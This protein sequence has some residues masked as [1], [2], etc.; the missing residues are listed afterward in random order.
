MTAKVLRL[1]GSC[2]PHAPGGSRAFSP[3][4]LVL[5]RPVGRGGVQSG[6]DVST[7]QRALN[8]VPPELGGPVEKLNPDGLVGHFTLGAIEKFQLHHF[9]F[10][11]GRVDVFGKTHAKLSSMRPAK[12]AFVS[13]A[14]ANLNEA[15]R[16]IRAAGAKL[17]QAQTELLTGGGLLGRRNLDLVDLH[18]GVLKSPN[19]REAIDRLKGVYDRMLAVFARPGGLWGVNA[20]DADPFTEPDAGAFT[21]WGGFDRPGQFAGWQRLDAICGIRGPRPRRMFR[22]LRENRLPTSRWTAWPSTRASAAP[23]RRVRLFPDIAHANPQVLQADLRVGSNRQG[24][25]GPRAPGR[26]SV[27]LLQDDSGSRLGERER[28][29]I[30]RRLACRIVSPG[31]A[32]AGHVDREREILPLPDVQHPPAS[33]RLRH[34][35]RIPLQA[36][37]PQ[38]R[39]PGTSIVGTAIRRFSHVLTT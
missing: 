21:F 32:G 7:V 20:F 37:A 19:P 27:R 39:S 23:L 22:Q 9:A 24:L 30:D 34:P 17:L 33:N 38:C 31:D 6:P 16:T 8:E 4:D 11:D 10:K 14:K 12:R 35:R 13:A 15:Q 26:R 29:W 3:T 25:A 36:A 18:F 1:S 2:I 5:T 28:F